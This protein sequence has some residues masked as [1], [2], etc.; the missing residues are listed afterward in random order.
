MIEEIGDKLIA[1]CLSETFL[2]KIKMYFIEPL[3]QYILER[4]Y[5]YIIMV[6]SIFM[7]MFICVVLTL[8]LIIRG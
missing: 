8:S 6:A 4:L 1:Y 5:P 3:I 2:D 7:L